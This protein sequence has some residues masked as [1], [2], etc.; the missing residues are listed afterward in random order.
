MECVVLV[1]IMSITLIILRI[2]TIPVI[3][4]RS[5]TRLSIA[6]TIA[7]IGKLFYLNRPKATSVQVKL[8]LFH[9]LGNAC[10]EQDDKKEL[11]SMIT[12]SITKRCNYIT[13]QN[14][15]VK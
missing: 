6:T 12:E 1:E 3:I 13:K 5:I 4:M 8:K 15:N 7:N 14:K 11:S 9:Q 10:Q 2:A